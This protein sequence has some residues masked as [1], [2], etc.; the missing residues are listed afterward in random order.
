MRI[1]DK[2]TFDQVK[3]NLSLNRGEL[4]DLQNKAAT[5]KRVTRPSDDP[6]A[7]TR[8]L[9]YR[10]EEQGIGQF[11]K[12]GNMARSLLD[13]T[14]QS[15]Q[16]LTDVLIR[17]KELAL[18][19][20]SDAGADKTSRRLVAQEVQQLY[21]QAVQIGN[22]K[23]GDR[24]LFG[25]YNTTASPFDSEGRYNGDDGQIMLEIN[26]GSAVQ[27]NVPGSQLF[28]GK[29]IGSLSRSNIRTSD[30]KSVEDLQRIQQSLQEPQGPSI[31]QPASVAG[32][33][34]P[35]PV[36][37]N[38]GGTNIFGLLK[39]VEIGLQADDKGALQESLDEIDAAVSQVVMARSMVGARATSLSTN[40]DS[41]TKS[42][43]DVKIAASQLEDVDTFEVVSDINRAEST[44]QATLAS[45]GKLV[46]PSLLDFLR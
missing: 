15:L 11:L 3:D 12:T 37:E 32:E 5:Q 7:A 25:G 26:N 9:S 38:D 28:L 43:I 23:L 24:F 10:T 6:L 16:D 41:L 17:V 35:D 33:V 22:R 8:V 34:S 40:A 42:N 30:P 27:V 20:A 19:Q 2:M 44:L 4:A 31:R 18:S 14:D 13:Y 21:G 29:N 46:Q 45:S 36:P 1:A 39:K